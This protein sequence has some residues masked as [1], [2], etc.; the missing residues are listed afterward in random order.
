M[1][2]RKLLT[3]GAG[4]HFLTGHF[5]FDCNNRGKG[6]RFLSDP[7][8]CTQQVGRLTIFT[9]H[10]HDGAGCDDDRRQWTDTQ[11]TLTVRDDP[12]LLIVYRRY[13][14]SSSA[15]CSDLLQSHDLCDVTPAIMQYF[16]YR[17]LIHF[18]L[19]SVY[20]VS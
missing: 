6:R 15:V 18:C 20:F 11:N 17:V 7:H 2:V 4:I 8:N 5:S 13:R 12:V 9:V 10:T 14:L 1:N 16:W 19:P 3:V